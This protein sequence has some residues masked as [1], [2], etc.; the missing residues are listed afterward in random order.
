METVLNLLPVP[1]FVMIINKIILYKKVLFVKYYLKY[2][3]FQITFDDVINGILR[4][5]L[6]G[7]LHP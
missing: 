6:Q 2:Y 3:K 7:K 5:K 1:E 4:H